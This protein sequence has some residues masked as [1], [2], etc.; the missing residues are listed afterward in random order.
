VGIQKEELGKSVSVVM[1]TLNEEAAVG[2]VVNDIKSV[3]PEAEIVVVDS[4]TDRTAEIAT[5]LGCVVVKQFPPKGYGNAMH[6]AFET[7]SRNYVVTLDC[8]DTYPV[9]AIPTLVTKLVDENLDFVSASRL[10]KRP[11][12]MPF[13]N[14]VANVVFCI[15][16]LFVAGIRSTDLH[17]GM[18][19]Y[20]RSLL[21]TY[22]YDPTYGALPVELQLGPAMAGYRSAEIFIDYLERK[23]VTK[24]RRLEGTITTMKRI[25]RCRWF[26]NPF[27]KELIAQRMKELA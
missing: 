5:E 2:K 17:T 6:K 14:Y 20:R 12:T 8:D 19:V 7:A 18:R 27:R 13:E 3:V 24:L 1:I 11:D 21:E 26:A 23:G 10:G 16:A 22:P 15:F 9:S 4:S 25:W